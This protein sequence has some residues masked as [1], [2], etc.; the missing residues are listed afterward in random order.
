MAYFPNS[1]RVLCDW[2]VIAG[3]LF[4]CIIIKDNI[5]ILDMPPVQ[6]TAII[7]DIEEGSKKLK[8]EMKTNMITAAFYC[9]DDSSIIDKV[10]AQLNVRLMFL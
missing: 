5:S 1:L 10:N 6:Q 8:L 2:I 3:D 9:Y 7:N 4:D